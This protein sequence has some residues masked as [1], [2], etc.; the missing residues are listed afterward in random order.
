MWAF[1]GERY[2]ACR[3]AGRMEESRRAKYAA[4][5]GEEGEEGMGEVEGE[6]ECEAA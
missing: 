3:Y 4:A 1:A 5:F 6:G 2:R